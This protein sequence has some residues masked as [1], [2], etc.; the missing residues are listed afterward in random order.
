MKN[1]KVKSAIKPKILFFGKPVL[2]YHNHFK[3]TTISSWT[4]FATENCVSQV[5]VNM[6]QSFSFA[7]RHFP[8]DK[9]IVL[10]KF[11]WS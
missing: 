9:W 7:G 6:T 10:R 2:R 3:L 8:T 1:K 4:L 5:I 11:F